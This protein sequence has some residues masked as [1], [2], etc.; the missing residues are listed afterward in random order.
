[1]IPAAFD[2]V[3][4][5]NLAEVLGLLRDEGATLLAGGHALLPAMK[6]RRQRPRLLVDLA[7]VAELRGI[8]TGPTVT[9]G[10]MTTTGEIERDALLRAAVPLLPRAAAVIADPLIRNRAT[11]GGSV[12]RADT[13]GDWPAL[14]L[15]AGATLH[16]RS[17]DA[18]RAVPAEEFFS[19]PELRPGEVLTH[20][21]MPAFTGDTRSTYLKRMHPASGYAVLGVAVVAA[22]GE[23]GRCTGCRIGITGAA[24]TAFRATAAEQHLLGRPLSPE[25]IVEAVATQ[26][27]VPVNH[28]GDDFASAGYRRHLLPVYLRRALTALIPAPETAEGAFDAH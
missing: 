19:D 10:A 17:A 27:A 2:Y 20:L 15:A 3:S 7:R 23:D 28:F 11:V 4:P 22:V 25:T 1:M 21:T 12:V 24:A 13:A 18:Q 8:T 5:G 9:L 14:A 26:S 16:L 6:L